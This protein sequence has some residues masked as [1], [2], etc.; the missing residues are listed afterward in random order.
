[1]ALNLRWL[2]FDTANAVFVNKFPILVSCNRILQIKQTGSC[3]RLKF[4]CS[5]DVDI[6]GIK[7]ASDLLAK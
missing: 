6:L 1:M 5:T 4:G 2:P 3:V 7:A